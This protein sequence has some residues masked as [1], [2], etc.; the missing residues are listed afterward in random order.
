MKRLTLNLILTFLMLSS[1]SYGGDKIGNGGDGVIMNNKIYLLDLLEMGVEEKPYF[2]PSVIIQPHILERISNEFSSLEGIPLELTAKKLSEIY[3]IDQPLAMILLQ[4][5]E[6]FEWRLVSK[7]LVDIPD[8]DT[9]LDII[10]GELIQLAIRKGRTIRINLEAW[11]DNR[12]DEAHKVAL[13]FH[14]VIYA[15]MP[16]KY[17]DNSQMTQSSSRAREING[18]LFSFNFQKEGNKGLHTI[19]ED[20]LPLNN[21]INNDGI[22]EASDGM[23]YF[24]PRIKFS[25]I[26]GFSKGTTHDEAI[27]LIQQYCNSNDLNRERFFNPSSPKKAYLFFTGGVSF[28]AASMGIRF[29]TYPSK[30][31]EKTY[32]GWLKRSRDV[33]YWKD[34]FGGHSASFGFSSPPFRDKNSPRTEERERQA[35]LNIQKQLIEFYETKGLS[36]FGQFK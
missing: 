14:E 12:F 16:P 8:E 27:T 1:L 5:M 19:I 2:N 11:N 36:W 3:A 9:P 17:I 20:E 32:V 15:L 34:S 21:E 7:S 26:E 28:N 23:I 33:Y 35:R 6:L 25:R 22:Y 10:R 4:T 13:I 18:Y 24:N 29:G 30:F 31:G